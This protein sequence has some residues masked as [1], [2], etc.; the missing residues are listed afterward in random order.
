MGETWNLHSPKLINSLTV[1][2]MCVR[3]DVCKCVHARVSAHMK[4]PGLSLLYVNR[5]IGS[6]FLIN[7]L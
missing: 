5:A 3:V 2:Q 6:L 4:V 7:L 1:P